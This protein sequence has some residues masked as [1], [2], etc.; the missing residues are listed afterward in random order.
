MQ[1]KAQ[2]QGPAA[3]AQFDETFRSKF[4]SDL[5]VAS[6]VERVKGGSLSDA[7][8]V[9]KA[10]PETEAAYKQKTEAFFKDMTDPA[11]RQRLVDLVEDIHGK[12]NPELISKTDLTEILDRVPQQNRDLAVALLNESAGLSSDSV[13]KA[14]LQALRSDIQAATGSA[15]PDNVYTLGAN[16][17]GNLLGYLYRKSN[18][19]SMSIRN[20]DTIADKTHVPNSIVLFDDLSSTQ[21]TLGQQKLLAQVPHVYAVDVGAFEKGINV[22][23]LSKGPAAVSQ[24]LDQ[25]LAEAEKVRAANPGL[26]PTGVAREVLSGAVDRS[27]AAIGPNVQVIRPSGAIK[28]P[29]A[30]PEAEL[31]AMSDV[32]AIHARIDVPKASREEIAGFLSG[33]AGQDRELAAQ[34]LAD[35][36]VHNSCPV[37]VARW[38]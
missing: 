6:A 30:V 20:I 22:V 2:E 34:M 25:L 4:A 24:K 35:G 26:L 19:M 11:Q 29:H 10:A 28:V 15:A 21:L 17:S 9:A 36:A 16:T 3:A 18:S 23:D 32:D 37:E 27:A 1:L 14:N 5:K 33:Y 8:A 31:S 38:S 7:Q 12:F 13:L